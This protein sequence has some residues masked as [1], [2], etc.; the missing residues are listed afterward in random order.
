VRDSEVGEVEQR[1]DLVHDR[2]ADR[3]R[4]GPHELEAEAEGLRLREVQ[5]SADV[6]SMASKAQ[7]RTST[8]AGTAALK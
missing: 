8:S 3:G 1:D 2:C 4:V 5:R 6:G 7:S